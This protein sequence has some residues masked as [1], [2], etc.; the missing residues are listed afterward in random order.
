VRSS[1]SSKRANLLRLIVVPV[2]M[3]IVTT[4]ISCRIVYK[5]VTKA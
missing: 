1:T 5:V 4:S 2:S 3:D